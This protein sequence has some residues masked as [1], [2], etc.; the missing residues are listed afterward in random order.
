MTPTE[1]FSATN[2]GANVIKVFPAATLGPNYFREL[3]GPF[4]TFPLMATGGISVENASSFFRA[5]ANFLGVGGALIPKTGEPAA[6]EACA[7]AARRL[8]SFA[9]ERPKVD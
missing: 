7:K 4:P 8:L 1:I 9:E 6:L 5:G 3:R 2:A